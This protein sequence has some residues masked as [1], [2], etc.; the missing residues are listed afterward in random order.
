MGKFWNVDAQGNPLFNQVHKLKKKTKF[1]LLLQGEEKQTVL[2]AKTQ[3]QLFPPLFEE[4]QN[5][6]P[7]SSEKQHT[8]RDKINGL[9]VFSL[10][11]KR[12]F[13]SSLEHTIFFCLAILFSF[14]SP[15]E[16]RGVANKK[17]NTS[18]KGE[19]LC[20]LASLSF[21]FDLTGPLVNCFS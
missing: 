14:V 6:L 5:P 13:F 18:G 7:P 8:G 2:K 11:G 3:K 15:G 21:F 9:I 12:V 10:L 4:I 20:F 17:E 19:V 16:D 1:L